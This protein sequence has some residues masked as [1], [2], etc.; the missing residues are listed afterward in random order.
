MLDNSPSMGIGATLADIQ[1]MNTKLGCAFACHEAWKPGGGP[2]YA[3][4]KNKQV[5]VK[6]RID[7]VREATEKLLEKAIEDQD[8]RGQYRIGIYTFNMAMQEIS[9]LTSNLSSVKDK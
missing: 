6:L 7:V 4:I 5:D 1:T 9:P 2:Y 8:D 3:P